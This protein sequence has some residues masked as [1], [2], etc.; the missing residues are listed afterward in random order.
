MET[1]N[2]KVLASFVAY[3]KAHPSERF[4]Q[5]L[6]NWSGVNF[7]LVANSVLFS[8]IDSISYRDEEDTFH[9]EGRIHDEL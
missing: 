2:S 9:W 6:C 4:W 7:I 1:R 5:A 3:C 8:T